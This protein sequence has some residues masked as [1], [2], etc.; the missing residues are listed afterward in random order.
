MRNVEALNAKS[1]YMFS[2]IAPLEQMVNAKSSE[3]G[4]ILPI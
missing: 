4:R 2:Y 3:S 1:P